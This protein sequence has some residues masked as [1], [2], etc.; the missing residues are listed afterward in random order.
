[1]STDMSDT[2]MERPP[3]GLIACVRYGPTASTAGRI[4][5]VDTSH[6]ISRALA[7]ARTPVENRAR[8]VRMSVTSG[9]GEYCA[10]CHKRIDASAVEY[11]VE[12]YV[13]AGLRTLHFHRICL[14]LWEELLPHSSMDVNADTQGG[15]AGKPSRVPQ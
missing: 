10:Y 15:A 4:E 9:T 5:N 7:L 8:V 11:E 13:A 3:I 14:H 2:T 1:M 6:W 12:A